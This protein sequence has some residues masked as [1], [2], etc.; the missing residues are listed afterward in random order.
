MR[1]RRLLE[2]LRRQDWTAVVIDFVIVVVGVFIG[3]QVA[4]W[5]EARRE[6]ELVRRHLSEVAEDLRKH[7]AL[8]DT[9]A[10]LTL[11]AAWLVVQV[12]EM[13]LPFFYASNRMQGTIVIVAAIGLVPALMFARA[14]EWIPSVLKRDDEVPREASIAPQA[15]LLEQ[16]S[17]HA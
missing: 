4:N 10:G 16:A 14:F 12:V 6:R 9:L 7:L 8:D 1:Y 11:A 2:N 17:T 3:I 5:N 13:A 15:A